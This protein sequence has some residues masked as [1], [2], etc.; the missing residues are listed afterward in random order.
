MVRDF[1]LIEDIFEKSPWRKKALETLRK[2]LEGGRNTSYS[3]N[4][5]VNLLLDMLGKGQTV[6]SFCA[7]SNIEYRV[8]FEWL[9]RHEE[10]K[11]AYEKIL[12]FTESIAQDVPVWDTSINMSFWRSRNHIFKRRKLLGIKGYY[13]GDA[14]QRL[15][16]VK[17]AYA[18]GLITSAEVKMEFELIEKEFKIKQ[19]VKAFEMLYG[20]DGAKDL[21]K[22][23]ASELLDFCSAMYNSINSQNSE[24]LFKNDRS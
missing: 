20:K 17:K 24:N 1:D 21:E 9:D 19:L 6:A 14:I 11:E 12:P 2:N 5:H 3:P 7:A 18:E 13:D 16:G 10:F 8:F 22:M 15:E 4:I 23:N